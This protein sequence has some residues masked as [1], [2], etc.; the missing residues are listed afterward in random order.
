MTKTLTKKQDLPVPTTQQEA[1]TL[2][3]SMGAARRQL[4]L[5][6][7]E[8]NEALARTQADFEQ[9]AQKFNQQI[10][11]EF[12]A[13]HAWAE[14][15]RDTLLTGTEKTV[16]LATGE[17]SWRTC[18]PSVTL[19]KPDEVLERLRK[20][21]LERFIRTK[22]EIDKQLLLKDPDAVSAVKGITITSKE[23]FTATPSEL[24]IDKAETSAMVVG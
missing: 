9:H 3:F 7:I 12:K 24:L 21:G 20:L 10:E 22:E 5:F 14:A 16:K 6:E 18:P 19:K 2:L 1:E 17:I 11:A 13:I 4:R 23:E 15:N 8:M